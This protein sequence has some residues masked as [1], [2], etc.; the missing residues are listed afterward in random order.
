VAIL[1]A[2]IGAL[3]MKLVSG[4]TVRR[5]A[6]AS[7]LLLAALPLAA[8]VSQEERR[9]HLFVAADIQQIQPGM[10]QDQV[11]GV[12]GTP[13][14]TSTV[15]SQAFYYISSTAKGAAFLE[16]TEVDRKILAVYFN[17]AGTVDQVAN[18]T[19][20]DGKVVDIIGRETGSAVG[21]KSLI[22]KLFKGVGK[23]QKLFDDAKG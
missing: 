10:T 1:A 9:G 3:R 20:Q 22:E 17:P 14:T 15:G 21:D 7:V 23:K 13:D 6:L 19:M 8:C 2:G 5:N 18:Y 16:P 12:L 11:R 4:S